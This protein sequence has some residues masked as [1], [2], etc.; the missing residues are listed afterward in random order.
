M[1]LGITLIVFC[2]GL[3]FGSFLNSVIYRLDDIKTI[4]THRSHCPH[5]KEEITWYDLVPL[6]SFIALTGRCRK[7]KTQISWQYPLV[8]IATAAI[9]AIIYWQ[10]G[11][12]GYSCLMMVMSCFLVVIFVYDLYHMLIPDLVLMPAIILWI[13]FGLCSF[14]PGLNLGINL[15]IFSSLSGAIV[16]VGFIGFIVLVTKGKGMGIG[17]I[18]L[19][20]LL[21]LILGWQNAI[22]GLFFAFVLGAVVGVFLL[23]IKAKK[24]KSELAFGPFLIIGFYIALFFGQNIV[25]WYLR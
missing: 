24:M 23:A 13:L 21:G 14:I 16:A 22:V 12:N 10:F 1:N 3:I 7:C 17:D 8:E 20:L 2:L 9:F 11:I 25:Q 19:A 6:F 4:F 18:K 5:C 15:N